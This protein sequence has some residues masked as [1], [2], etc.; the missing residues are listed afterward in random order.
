MYKLLD[1]DQEKELLRIIRNVYPAVIAQQIIGSPY[2][3]AYDAINIRRA[4]IQ[5]EKINEYCGTKFTF[6]D[7]ANVEKD[8]PI[9]T[10]HQLVN[11]NIHEE[12]SSQSE[13]EEQRSLL[14]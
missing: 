12:A 9:I 13:P 7:I 4:S 1:P 6:A 2:L 3:T 11:Q 8:E 10:S 14:K 5:L